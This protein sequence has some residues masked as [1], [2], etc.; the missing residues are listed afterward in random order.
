MKQE[1]NSSFNAIITEVDSA[2]VRSSEAHKAIG[3]KE[4]KTYTSNGQEWELI[5]LEI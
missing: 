5:L 4:L 2:N 1:L 3:F